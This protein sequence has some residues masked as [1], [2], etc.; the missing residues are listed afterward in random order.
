MKCVISVFVLL[1]ISIYCYAD[2]SP[3]GNAYWSPLN[4][5]INAVH[6]KLY[7]PV[8]T[9][10]AVFD[11][12]PS[13]GTL[14]SGIPFQQVDIDTPVYTMALDVMKKKLYT[15]GP[16]G[17]IRIFSL[18]DSGAITGSYFP[19]L[20]RDGTTNVNSLNIDFVNS[21]LLSSGW[22]N[23]VLFVSNLGPDGMP[24]QDSGVSYNTGL[25]HNY[26][27]LM[28]IANKI[29]YTGHWNDYG[30]LFNLDGNDSPVGTFRYN[31]N[32][33]SY[34][35]N[36]D[37]V[38][39]R[40]YWV[41]NYVRMW[42]LNSVGDT[43]TFDTFY[44]PLTPIYNLAIDPAR[45]R[46]FIGGAW[47][48]PRIVFY[49]MDADGKLGAFID[50]GNIGG[51]GSCDWMAYEPFYNK[52]Y[53]SFGGN[54]SMFISYNGPDSAL[55]PIKISDGET[56]TESTNVTLKF[57]HSNP[58]FMYVSG[59]LLSIG[60]PVN[61]LNQWV[62][63][64][65]GFWMN[66]GDTMR[67]QTLNVS[68]VITPDFGEK[69]MEVWYVGSVSGPGYMNF[70][71]MMRRA[72]A[73][74]TYVAKFPTITSLGLS[75]IDYSRSR[76]DYSVMDGKNRPVNVSIQYKTKDKDWSDLTPGSG[77]DGTTNL[78]ASSAGNSHYLIWDIEKDIPE[79][80]KD[81]QLRIKANNGDSD[82]AW[83]ETL[84]YSVPDW[85]G[86]DLRAVN[87]SVRKPD[88]NWLYRAR[89]E[90]TGVSDT[91]IN[92]EVGIREENSDWKWAGITSGTLI[93]IEN[94][95]DT[96]VYSF[97]VRMRTKEGLFSSYSKSVSIKLTARQY[98]TG[99][100][101]KSGGKVYIE[102]F[103]ENENNNTRVE[104]DEG[105]FQRDVTITIERFDGGMYEVN[106]KKE[107][108]MMVIE[109]DFKKPATL[110]LKYDREEVAKL[111]WAEDDLVLYHFD[112]LKWF[113]IGGKADK[114]NNLISARVNHF[115]MFKI[116]L[117]MEK[118]E[119]TVVPDYFSPNRDGIRDVLYFY[120]P[121][122]EMVDKSEIRIYD[123]NGKFI[124]A[125]NTSGTNTPYW[126]GRTEDNVLCEA[127]LYVCVI[128]TGRK[129]IIKTVTLVK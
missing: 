20:H 75:R 30:S 19:Y 22:G 6:H 126:D 7:A 32:G 37:T 115:S 128:D 46:M 31:V 87:V 76:I 39:K 1:Y 78:T 89:L 95:S 33:S 107:N 43:D 62:S 81:V 73:K 119:V 85:T 98:G 61:N 112:G 3:V 63:C 48:N 86:N 42:R 58:V 49:T 127:G 102:D 38:N 26:V 121:T 90:W 123:I 21:K 36:L 50:S 13:S 52:I 60:N 103:D 17:A 4:F 72:T 45:R 68:A 97:K 113:S 109:S 8:G 116:A 47:P 117:N 114:D 24:M 41:N 129:I 14:S 67:T 51:S 65:A 35:A 83:V 92:Y 57:Q 93:E 12:D 105:T 100:I 16:N 54:S 125:M 18:S 64:G 66:A 111:G 99:V 29:I 11:L 34:N 104:L 59:N 77:G 28:D 91:S 96:P 101:G 74:I 53:G 10:I 27:M 40:L 79:N 94:L 70:T 106:G 118:P 110:K 69:T 5:T 9:K 23:G 44:S 56:V 80:A 108:G 84:K 124:R 71:G 120:F 15:G 82:G 25:G 88:S 122:Q 55:E 2:L